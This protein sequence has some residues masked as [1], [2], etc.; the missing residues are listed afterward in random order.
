MAIL[1][2]LLNKCSYFALQLCVLDEIAVR[3]A[4]EMELVGSNESPRPPSCAG[5]GPADRRRKKRCNG[6][7][8]KCTDVNS[9]VHSSRRLEKS[10]QKGGAWGSGSFNLVTKPHLQVNA[11]AH[12][13][14]LSLQLVFVPQRL[15]PCQMAMQNANSTWLL[16]PLFSFFGI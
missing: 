9:A 2:K 15:H 3:K 4:R 5:N 8:K 6:V 11:M 13:P 16:F 1:A 7:V 10:Q 14:L 12:S